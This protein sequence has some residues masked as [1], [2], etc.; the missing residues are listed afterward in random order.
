VKEQP[1]TNEQAQKVY[2]FS[3]RANYTKRVRA[4]EILGKNT[5]G[6]FDA[7][8]RAAFNLDASDHLS[9]FTRIIRRGKGKYPHET[10]YGELNP[11]EQ[12][13]A[14]KVRLAGLGLEVGAELEY[15]YD[16]GDWLD[17]TLILESIGEPDRSAKYPRVVEAGKP[18]SRAAKYTAHGY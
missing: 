7:L 17:H 13:P 12:T 9:Q 6:D 18:P 15:V 1:F 10:P 4:V 14:R 16:F 2:R 3:A 11:F 5:L 8:M